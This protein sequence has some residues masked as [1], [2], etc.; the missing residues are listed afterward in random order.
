M[1][2]RNSLIHLSIYGSLQEGAAIGGDFY[3]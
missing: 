1:N 2:L 3:L